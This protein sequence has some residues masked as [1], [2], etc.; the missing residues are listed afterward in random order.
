MAL[1]ESANTANILHMVSQKNKVMNG[2][3]PIGA[4]MQMESAIY[5]FQE[6]I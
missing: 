2:H 6:D 1:I 3:I 5:I 4:G